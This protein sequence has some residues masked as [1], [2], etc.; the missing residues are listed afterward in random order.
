MTEAERSLIEASLDQRQR[1]EA[2][3]ERRRQE[4]FEREQRQ[5]AALAQAET[6]KARA[7]TAAERARAEAE[8]AR[9]DV[10][11]QERGV[12]ADV[13]AR[14]KHKG[15]QLLGALL[16]AL[17]MLGSAVWAWNSVNTESE[18]AQQAQQQAHAFRLAIEGQAMNGGAR[19]GGEFRGMQ[20]ILVAH[21]LLADREIDTIVLNAL[22][23]RPRL[24]KLILTESPVVS[25]AYSWDG[26]RLTSGGE[27]GKLRLWDAKTGQAVGEPIAA[28]EGGLFSEGVLSVAWSPDGTRLAS[29]GGDGKLLVI[30]NVEGWPAQLCSRLNRNLSLAEWQDWVDK[31]IP[32]RRPC[33]DL[34]WPDDLPAG[35]RQ[36]VAQAGRP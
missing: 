19:P 16:A 32:Y 17:A 14:L 3:A 2:E 15:R 1:Q 33:P 31:D 24:R 7:E 22:Q 18:R 9:A 34:P 35:Q 13:A 8:S 27:D 23:L 5:L 10:E 26:T 4:E 28:H 6:D 29:G 25:A 21:R 12:Q 20:Q 30:P 11:A 36:E